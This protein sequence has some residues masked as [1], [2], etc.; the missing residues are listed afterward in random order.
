MSHSFR[1]QKM[2]QDVSYAAVERSNRAV[3]ENLLD[4][5]IAAFYEDMPVDITI[6]T[7]NVLRAGWNP[8]NVNF[9]SPSGMG[10]FLEASDPLVRTL[11]MEEDLYDEAYGEVMD[12]FTDVIENS[13]LTQEFMEVLL[14]D[15]LLEKEPFYKAETV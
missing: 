8:I 15:L 10:I 5:I 3:R 6:P 2:Q 4:E 14:T 9:I 11:M 7:L 12:A 1:R 13:P